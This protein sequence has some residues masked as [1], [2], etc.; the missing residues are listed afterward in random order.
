MTLTKEQMRVYQREKRAKAKAVNQSVNQAPKD[1]NPPVN[2]SKPVNQNVNWEAEARQLRREVEALQAE[3]ARLKQL[4]A[5]RP[6]V[7]GPEIHAPMRPTFAGSFSRAAQAKGQM[8]NLGPLG[9]MSE[10]NW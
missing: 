3:V 8:P 10:D 1:V 7:K 5:Q 6:V 4:L 9:R 2:P